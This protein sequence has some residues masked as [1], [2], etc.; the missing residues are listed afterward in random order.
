MPE[1]LDDLPDRLAR[2]LATVRWAEPGELRARARRRT[3]LT[4]VAASLAVLLVVLGVGWRTWFAGGDPLSVPVAPASSSASH[5]ATPTPT[6]T[7]TPPPAPTMDPAW[8]PPEALI[9]P[10]DVG[11]G[12]SLTAVH[13][14]DVEPIYLWHFQ[15]DRCPAYEGLHLTAWQEYN[16][17]RTHQ[18]VP[19][20]R[21]GYFLEDPLFVQALRY[22]DGAKASTVIQDVRRL[23]SACPQYEGGPDEASTPA[24]PSHGFFTWTL[25]DEG[26]AGDESLLIGSTAGSV[27]DAT[28]E[29]FGATIVVTYAVVRVSDLVT[30]ISRYSSDDAEIARLGKRAA[31][32]L[33][34]ASIPRC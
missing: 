9:Q 11:T 32:R 24:R 5:T 8:I 26:F 19:A 28:G 6:P 3:A 13:S 27:A 25:L 14:T 23:L 7:A 10:E 31:T 30:V 16:F 4:V 18:V 15:D 12:Q 2:A 17:M 1:R 22:P 34:T 29:H 33:C 21:N 20:G